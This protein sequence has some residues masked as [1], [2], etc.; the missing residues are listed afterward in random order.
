M[1][2][3]RIYH[4]R[5]DLIARLNNENDRVQ[6][7]DTEED[8]AKI[9]SASEA[10]AEFAEK[11]D[12]AVEDYLNA[13]Y[14]EDEDAPA[15]M[16]YSRREMIE[17]WALMQASLSKLAWVLRFDGNEAYQRMINSLDKGDAVDMSGL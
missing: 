14:E 16:G 10:V 1:T 9:A 8:E 11:L 13:M 4:S 6:W 15:H 12:A 5:E 17:R 2:V 3:T 7:Q